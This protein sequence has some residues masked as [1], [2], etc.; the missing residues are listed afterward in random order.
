MRALLAATA[1]LPA[2]VL[3]AG[4]ASAA[5]QAV[6]AQPTALGPAGPTDE[7]E[8]PAPAREVD[9]PIDRF[10]F[11]DGVQ[12]QVST[13]MDDDNL[14][15]QVALPTGPSIAHRFSFTA[16]TP[17]QSG[18]NAMPASLDALV[19]GTRATLSWGYFDIRVGRPDA[20]AKR[21]RE[22]AR[23]LCWA[24]NP[25]PGPQNQCAV[26]GYAMQNYDRRNLEIEQRHGGYGAADFGIDATVG[27][28]DFEWV[29]RVTLMPQK[30]RRTDWSV[31]GHFAYYFV[32]SQTAFRASAAYQ[33]AYEA[34]EEELLCPPNAVDPATQCITARGGAPTRNENFL[35][36]AGLRHRFLNSDGNLGRL[37]LAPLVTYDVIDNVWGVDVPVYFVPG[38]N[39]DLTGGI[40]FGYRSDRDD[41]FSIS[42][43]VGTTFSLWGS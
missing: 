32:G 1:L 33:R 23:R 34:V 21:L 2:L 42:V 25:V 20:I 24:A 9:E 7:A 6:A 31:A 16:S 13:G 27:L 8:K 15:L 22:R 19:N 35:L 26:S 4:D 5:T 29:D 11:T 12:L 38:E 3:G 41:K 17:L 40:R 18:G 43:F 28:N 36:S 30:D 14:T 39:D 37:A 10:G